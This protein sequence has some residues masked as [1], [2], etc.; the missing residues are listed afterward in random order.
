MWRCLVVWHY[1]GSHG[2]LRALHKTRTCIWAP[3][4]YCKGNFPKLINNYWW[5]DISSKGH[6]L[7]LKGREKVDCIRVM[8][9]LCRYP[10]LRGHYGQFCNKSVLSLCL[11]LFPVIYMLSGYF[12]NG[13]NQTESM[14]TADAEN[15]QHLSQLDDPIWLNPRGESGVVS[16]KTNEVC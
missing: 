16:I 14:S 2:Y 11:F 9:C 10:W 5:W 15:E 8:L 7:R 13:T 12:F 1:Q 4:S 6:S 3:K